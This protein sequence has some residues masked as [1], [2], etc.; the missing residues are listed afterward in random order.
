MKK[1]IEHDEAIALERVVRDVYKCDRGG[2]MNVAEADILEYDPMEAIIAVFAPLY[3]KE[4]VIDDIDAF[5]DEYQS[6]FRYTD[7]YEYDALKIQEFIRR[8]RELVQKYYKKN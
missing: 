7:E 5:V 3:L 1:V 6:I 4:S 2:V 8:F